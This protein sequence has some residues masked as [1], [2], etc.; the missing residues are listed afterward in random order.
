MYQVLCSKERITVLDI[1]KKFYEGDANTF[2]L[3]NYLTKS[4]CKK[5]TTI[6]FQMLQNLQEPQHILG[7]KTITS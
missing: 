4:V 5:T 7:M 2:D 3:T 6:H 1:Y